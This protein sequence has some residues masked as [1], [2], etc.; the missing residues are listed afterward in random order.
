[1]DSYSGFGSRPEVTNLGPM[2]EKEKVGRVICVGL[3]F[4]YCVGSTAL[5]AA[6]LGFETYIVRDATRS[7]G[8]KSEQEMQARLVEAGVM[9]I[10]SEQ[11]DL[12][13]RFSNIEFKKTV[14]EDERCLCIGEG[15]GGPAQALDDP[16]DH[17][18]SSTDKVET[19]GA[20]YNPCGW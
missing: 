16:Y 7:V 11:I 10:N 15:A 1:M 3:A 12:R 14:D 5:D 8:L 6:S 13:K 17:L 4:D 20:S 19:E 2:L 18:P 9:V